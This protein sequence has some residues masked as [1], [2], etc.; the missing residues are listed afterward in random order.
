MQAWLKNAL[1]YTGEWLDYQMR[2]TRQPG[3]SIAV[4]HKGRVVFERAY[5][6]ADAAK[7]ER[8]TPRHRF[9]VASHSKS[10]TAAAILKLREAGKLSLDD[11]VGRYID[12]LHP[13]VAEAT[14]TQLLSHGAGLVRDGADAGQWLDRRP[15]ASEAEL[16][17]ALAE[18]PMITP[19]TRMK[20][21]NHGFGLL[22]L[23]IEAVT[24]ESYG[25]WISRHVV[26]ASKLKETTPDGPAAKGTP[27][28]RGHSAEL[29]LGHRVVIPGDNPT[30]VLAP[31]TGFVSTATDLARYFA[32]LD[33]AAPRSVLSPASRR[34]MIHKQWRDPHS[35]VVSHYGLGLMMGNAG[36]WDWAGHGGGF[37]SCLSRTS[38]LPGR[39]LCVSVLTNATDG[40]A[41]AWSD[42][43]IKILKT[44]ADNPLP[45]ARARPW[46]GRWWSLWG[47]ADLVPFGHKVMIAAPELLNP[48]SGA[49]EITVSAKDKG[50]ISLAGGY[51]SHGEDARLVRGRDGKVRDVWLG[52]AR[53]VSESRIKTEMKKRYSV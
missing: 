46:T 51:G 15:F 13:D 37:Q 16:R 43:V 1:D 34:A 39:E 9:R 31:A 7:G 30:H 5:G 48:F 10:F 11:P 33:P 36:G 38:M 28:A 35:T 21:S 42:G 23:V 53:L 18:P 47:T 8:L 45:S 14:L 49:E 12:G 4:A 24:G 50:V 44:F 40:M 3:C 20:Y 26:A 2:V 17:A 6:H 29:P 32:S 41:N 22:G 19:N 52:G 25:Q 27:V